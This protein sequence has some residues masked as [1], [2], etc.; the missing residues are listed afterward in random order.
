MQVERVRNAFQ[1]LTVVAGYFL[2]G[3]PAHSASPLKLTGALAGSVKDAG[4]VPQMGA[5]VLL[6]NR[7]DR[8]VQKALTDSRGDFEF[9]TVL[10]DV[11]SVRVTLS[12]FVPAL[13]RNI[14]I[15]PGMRSVLAINLAT[16]LSS[17][18]FV[19]SSTTPGTLMSDEWK[20]VLRSSMT[21]RPVLR[22]IPGVDI[23]A[24]A[25]TQ[26]TTSIFSDTRGTVSVSSGDSSPSGGLGDRSD[27]GTTFALATSM[28]GQNQVQFT[29]N[30]GLADSDLPS[31]GFRT[32]FSRNDLGGPEVKLR[33]QQVSLPLQPSPVL[34]AAQGN[35]PALRTM[36]VSLIERAELADGVDLDY[37]V[38]LDSVTF[39]DRLNYFSPFARL[40]Y[41]LGDKGVIDIGYSSGAP[42]VDLLHSTKDDE[43]PL[44][45]DVVAL[46][47]L[48]RIS[49]RDGRTFVQRT[50]NFEVGYRIKLGDRTISVGAY[51]EV[52]GNGALTMSAPAGFYSSADL[53]PE[54]SS[55]SSVFNIGRY[56]RMGYSAS[57]T[58]ALNDDLHVT[59][60]YGRGGVLVSDGNTL[61]S[62]DPNELRRMIRRDQRHWLRG[63][64]AGT[65]PKVGTRY[66]ASY[67]WT[68]YASVVPGH[69]YLTQNIYPD[70]GLNVRLRQ[71]IPSFGP[72]PGRLEASAELR[73][74]LAQ[75]YLPVS[76]SDGRRLVLTQSPRA[77][78]GGVTFIF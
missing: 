38:S 59:V 29:G 45:D 18:E 24:P 22:F 11:Y 8:L 66:S 69:V 77:V 62:S 75:G 65:A 40:S 61:T 37:G 12:S 9:D 23:S 30:F 64:I 28:F 47:M 42:P 60:A 35:A 78:R 17:I 72:F 52:I 1:L 43:N 53:L 31:A 2:F 54:L 67:E 49:L 20:W 48:P 3:G 4:G 16:L 51:R 46:S 26:R 41:E 68:D 27:L 56:S 74:M 7:Y 34:G 36:S 19:Y 73:N 70:T 57:V 15:Q 71:P 5:M 32:S 33:M 25:A 21:T 44:R 13:K 58:Q 6:F 55:N 14:S 63:R 76:A 10:P 50:Q 39:I